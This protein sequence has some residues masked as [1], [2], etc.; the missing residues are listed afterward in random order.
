MQTSVFLAKLTGPVLLVIGIAL[1]VNGQAIR[2]MAEDFLQHRAII[3]L[4]GFLALIGGLAVVNTHSVWTADWRGFI[5]VLGWLALIG[6]VMRIVMPDLT[7]SIGNRMI[8]ISWLFP[9]EGALL[10]VLGG[11][12]SYAGYVG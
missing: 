7:R 12:L 5:T 2:D 3:F 6:G 9:A 11:W 10:V 1:V 4:S 8:A